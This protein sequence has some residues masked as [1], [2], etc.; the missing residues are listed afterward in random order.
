MFDESAA[1]AS[2]SK[3]NLEICELKATVF[4]SHLQ[5]PNR[6]KRL[7]RILYNTDQKLEQLLDEDKFSTE[8]EA[9][10]SGHCAGIRKNGDYVICLRQKERL[11]VCSEFE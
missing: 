3:N 10:V 2:R 5:S 4:I 11:H 7:K 1:C 6:H 8:G 9:T